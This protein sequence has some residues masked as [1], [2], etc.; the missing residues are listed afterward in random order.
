MLWPTDGPLP[1]A[2][3]D[4][5][6]RRVLQ[7]DF[8]VALTVTKVLA[9]DHAVRRLTPHKIL[10]PLAGRRVAGFVQSNSFVR[11]IVQSDSFVRRSTQDTLHPR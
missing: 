8:V 9:V 4:V 5:G 10:E 7:P 11:S 1:E 3:D 6:R 2:A